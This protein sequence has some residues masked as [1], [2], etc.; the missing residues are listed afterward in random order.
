MGMGKRHRLTQDSLFIVTA[1]LA[2]SSSHEFYERLNQGLAADCFDDFVEDLC[3][4]FYVTGKGRPSIPPG[5][6]LS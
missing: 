5:T 4:P 2:R 1:S 3:E 6:Y